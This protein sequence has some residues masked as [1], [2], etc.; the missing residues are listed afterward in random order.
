M[1]SKLNNKLEFLKQM[2]ESEELKKK[3]EESGVIGE[4]VFH[5]LEKV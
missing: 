1:N 2:M 5:V 4:P 3:M